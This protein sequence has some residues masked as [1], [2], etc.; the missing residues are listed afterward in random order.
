L[1]DLIGLGFWTNRTESQTNYIFEWLTADPQLIRRKSFTY[2][3]MDQNIR[4]GL[5]GTVV[6]GRMAWEAAGGTDGV[7]GNC[8]VGLRRLAAGEAGVRWMGRTESSCWG[9]TY[10]ARN[11]PVTERTYAK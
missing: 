9:E 4:R 8:C 3:P 10:D 7:G 2:L 1:P 5:R 11:A 6:A